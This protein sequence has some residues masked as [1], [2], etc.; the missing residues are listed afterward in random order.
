MCYLRE[1]VN[2][3]WSD[4]AT[5]KSKSKAIPAQAQIDP[6]GPRRLVLP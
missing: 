5:P 2:V 4:S 3:R 1:V 6:D